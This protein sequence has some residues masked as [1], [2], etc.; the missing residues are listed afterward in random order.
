MREKILMNTGY[1]FF[2][3]DITKDPI[4]SK[5][6]TYM[7]SKTVRG[8]GPEST[9]YY[10]ADWEDVTLPHDFVIKGNYS[11]KH[12][13]SH[14]SL[15][16][17]NAWYRR[18]FKLD[19]ADANKRFSFI[20]EG[21]GKNSKIWIN[22]HLMGTNSSM[23]NTFEVD[24]TAVAHI[25]EINTLAV[26]IDNSD[27][28]GWWYEGS[29]IYRNVWLQKTD[30]LRLNWWDN[31]I[32]SVNLKDDDFDIYVSGMLENYSDATRTVTIKY[33]LKENNNTVELGQYDLS[34]APCDVASY[35]E[36]FTFAD[37]TRWS[38]DNP[39]LYT[40]IVT[41]VENGEIIDELTTKTGFR[42]VRF[43]ADHGLFI[44]NQPIKV[45]GVCI[46]Q[47]HG[48]LGVAVPAAV[49]EFRIKKLK[50]MGVNAYRCAH[51]NPSIHILELCDKYGMI[52]MDE[53]R[54]FETSHDAFLQIESMVKRDRNHPSIIMWSAG[55]EEPTQSTVV[56][57]HILEEIKMF[58]KRLDKTRPVTLA[59]NGGF[60]GSH[61]SE[62]SD[63][64]SINYAI[65]FYDKSHEIHP[66]KCIM[67]TEAGATR[68]PRGVYFPTD[69]VLNVTAYDEHFPS[70]GESFRR[71]W[72]E[73]DTRNYVAG[74]FYWPG[75][76]YRGEA[77]Y[78]QLTNMGGGLDSCC[79]EKDNFYLLQS[80][81]L[82]EPVLHLFPHWNLFGHEG[83]AIR[84]M[85][86]SNLD[87]VEL[88]VNGISAGKQPAN[89]YDQN[90]WSVPFAPGEIVAIGY[91][92]G[93][94]VKRTT[95]KTTGDPAAL[96]IVADNQP[97]S[98]GVVV[99]RVFATD[100]NGDFV[101][102]SK[103]AISH[104]VEN[105]TLLGASN[106][107]PLDQ[108]SVVAN[109]HNLNSGLLQIIARQDSKDTPI[110][111]TATNGDMSATFECDFLTVP[112]AQLPVQTDK[113]DLPNFR[114]WPITLDVDVAARVN[115][116]DM[117]TSIPFKFGTDHLSEIFADD[118]GYAKYT[119]R[120][121]IPD[122][123][124][125]KEVR[126][127]IENVTGDTEISIE[128]D[129][130]VWPNVQPR[131]GISQE[132]IKFADPQGGNI[133]VPVTKFFKNEKVFV[134]IVNKYSDPTCGIRGKVY[135]ELH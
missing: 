114:V 51:N 49:E 101:P 131:L 108:T 125:E 129:R 88:I 100:S 102:N 69:T 36:V 77:E 106:G 27:F 15:K 133:T 104:T 1:K 40:V 84:V 5:Q 30:A 99:L 58:I 6:D 107:D 118:Y 64:L 122:Y 59:L 42:T 46:H 54:W 65:K 85:T 89:K 82:D 16:R 117:N 37:A 34:V 115:Y 83:E 60:Y 79:F 66:D 7:M 120:L 55:N 71:F 62:S 22:G 121:L 38:I 73:V 39:F 8:R 19:S 20:F 61:A 110:K 74:L 103:I 43:T 126:I 67:V 18:Y 63:T 44:N 87:E 28:E 109:T 96:N 4:S 68:N 24:F 47:D 33:A 3:G 48:S 14:G 80:F 81:W 32:Y 10:D 97:N 113:M 56:G 112:T 41:V 50:E 98:D 26:Y 12:N 25:G 21:V 119:T 52:V 123:V 72:K 134:H 57:K 9:S 76:E 90:E 13:G 35:S 135:W 29:G 70:F 93:A 105:G 94:E 92:D 116:D 127:I 124:G 23:Y 95:V 17:N 45:K 130:N 132:I 86:Y 128:H 75:I 53:N 91:K 31:F 111:V 2:E 78:P 11:D